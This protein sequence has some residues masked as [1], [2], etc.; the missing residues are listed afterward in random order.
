MVKAVIFD[1][2]DT[3]GSK[4]FAIH[5][6]L[7]ERFKIKDYP[8]YHA[9]YENCV[10]LKK[11]AS[12]E[13][14]AKAFLDKF[15]IQVNEKNIKDIVSMYDRGIE[16]AKLFD[17]IKEILKSLQKK[18]KLGLISNTTNFEISFVDRTNIR[19]FFNAVV[20]S[21]DVGKTKPALEI[22]REIASR[23]SVKLSDC[24]FIDDSVDNIEA[25]RGYGLKAIHF[26]DV[27]QLKKDLAEYI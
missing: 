19:T 22:F 1:L 6:L 7:Q 17:G 25:A 15:N 13:E 20:C 21:F 11:W 9:D 24:L 3:L 8:D 2:W 27:S 18:Y 23:L 12:K 26:K 16:N 5:R 4:G 14:L 10:Q